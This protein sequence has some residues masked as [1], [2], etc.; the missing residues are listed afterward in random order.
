VSFVSALTEFRIPQEQ[1]TFDRRLKRHSAVQLGNCL[2][3]AL[4]FYFL[5]RQEFYAVICRKRF[6]LCIQNY[7]YDGQVTATNVCKAI[8]ET[9]NMEYELPWQPI[10]MQL[11]DDL[12]YQVVTNWAG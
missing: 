2:A 11:L 10:W 7:W 3:T 5:S 8:S 6:L 4:F 12:S 1:E 9:T